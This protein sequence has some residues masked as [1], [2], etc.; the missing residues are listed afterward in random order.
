M[1]TGRL[2]AY[3]MYSKQSFPISKNAGNIYKYIHTYL[4]CVIYLNMQRRVNF[5]QKYLKT[6]SAFILVQLL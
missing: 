2:S 6:P 5:L 3:I 1:F 4:H